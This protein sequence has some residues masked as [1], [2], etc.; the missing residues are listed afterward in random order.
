MKISDSESPMENVWWTIFNSFFFWQNLSSNGIL[1]DFDYPYMENN[2]EK[3]RI[4]NLQ[5]ENC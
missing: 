1:M 3:V 4:S 2:I 5:I